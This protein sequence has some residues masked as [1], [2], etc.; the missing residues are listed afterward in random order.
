MVATLTHRNCLEGN[1]F[2]AFLQDVKTGIRFLRKHAEEYQIDSD[3]IGIWGTSSGGNTALLVGLTGDDIR[4]ETEENSGYSDFVKVVVDCFGPT[5]MIQIPPYTNEIFKE[6]FQALLG[7][8]TP[9]NRE[10]LLELNPLN[11]VEKGK[12]I[13]PFYCCM[14][15]KINWWIIIKVC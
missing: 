2:P 8:D 13:L 1:P 7:E 11:Q 14:A 4:Y 15:I 10:K 6:I 12:S 5:D 3:R 9:E